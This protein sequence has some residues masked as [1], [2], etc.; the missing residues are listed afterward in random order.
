MGLL[1]R[2]FNRTKTNDTAHG[3]RSPGKKALN[4]TPDQLS[5]LSDGELLAALEA[6][7]ESAAGPGDPAAQAENLTGPAKDFLI[8]SRFHREVYQGGLCQFFVHSSRGLSPMISDALKRIGAED[9]AAVYDDFI[10]RHRIDPNDLD[11]FIIEDLK[12]YEGQAARYPFDD[13][14]GAYY[15]LGQEHSLPDHLLQYARTHLS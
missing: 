15:R 2:I 11:S 3:L 7:I 13:F 14:D 9:Y 4:L 1:D 10:R 12:E 6:R 5:E 8:L